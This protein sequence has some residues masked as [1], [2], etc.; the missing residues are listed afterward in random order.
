MLPFVFI[1]PNKFLQGAFNSRI[2]DSFDSKK[3]I[4]ELRESPVLMY[5]STLFNEAATASEAIIEDEEHIKGLCNFHLKIYFL[6]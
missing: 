2:C 5:K 6:P 4:K 3:I 1:V